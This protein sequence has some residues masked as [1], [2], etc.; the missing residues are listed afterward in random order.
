MAFRNSATDPGECEHPPVEV[1]AHHVGVED[2]RLGEQGR[3]HAQCA[4]P[5]QLSLNFFYEQIFL[6]FNISIFYKHIFLRTN[7][8]LFNKYFLF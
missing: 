4:P 2:A 8:F 1:A 7:I 3:H 6:L 5:T